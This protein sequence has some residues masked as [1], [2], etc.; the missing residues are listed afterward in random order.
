E[1]G[2]APGVALFN[3]FS[4]KQTPQKIE[5]ENPLGKNG[6]DNRSSNERAHRT[7]PSRSGRKVHTGILGGLRDEAQPVHRHENTIDASKS[8]PEMSFPQGFAQAS[9]E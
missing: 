9:S 4:A 8:Q 1:C 3:S 6:D 5:Q 7:N 2:G